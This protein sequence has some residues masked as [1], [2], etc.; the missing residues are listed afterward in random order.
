MR[1][2]LKY[3]QVHVPFRMLLGNF[4][5][6]VIASGIQPEIGFDYAILDSVG[7]R[8]CRE[9]ADRLTDAGLRV[10]F[11]APFM[12]LR[13]GAVDP[14]IRAVSR[15]RLQ[16][17]FD[18]VPLFRPRAV[19]C[20]PSF[21]A[22]YYVSTEMQWLENSLSLWG[23]FAQRAAELDTLLVLENVYEST[24]RQ[25]ARLLKGLASPHVRFCLDTGHLNAFSALTLAPWLEELG[26]FLGEIHLHD[27]DGSR[28]AH[29][30][31]GEGTF[32]FPELFAFLR[33]REPRPILTL[34][35]H[36]TEHFQR[37]VATLEKNRLFGLISS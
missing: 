31:I 4:L 26:D 12:D 10:T 32:P 15:E 7:K 14:R 20:H 16:Q 27:N 3:L 33:E 1:E 11:H 28:D 8:E 18:L 13:P 5:D 19:V 22:R 37:T 24:P 2:I 21:D 34:E 35:A 6:T 9:V 30:P 23:D 29:L 36:S 25:L 17:V